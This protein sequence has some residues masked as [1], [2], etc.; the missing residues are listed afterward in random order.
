MS[1]SSNKMVAGVLAGLFLSAGT[2]QAETHIDAD[3]W[4]SPRS[5]ERVLNLPAVRQVLQDWSRRE[6]AQIVIR[7]PGGEAG[8]LWAE[9]L[10]DWL[11]ALGV[12]SDAIR[13]Q[14]GSSRADAVELGVGRQGG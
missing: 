5:A 14:P 12:P 10:A 9:E 13:R 6:E 11:V 8:L 3:V 7:Y 1:S 4:A 2:L